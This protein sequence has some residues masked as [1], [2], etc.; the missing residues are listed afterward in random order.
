MQ[1]RAEATTYR[2]M[3]SF[4]RKCASAIST[5]LCRAAPAASLRDLEDRAKHGPMWTIVVESMVVSD[6]ISPE[7]T[8][9]TA[10][11]RDRLPRSPVA[12]HGRSGRDPFEVDTTCGAASAP[13]A[14]GAPGAPSAPSAPGA[15]RKVWLG[16]FAVGDGW[17]A[18]SRTVTS[19]P[20]S[21]RGVAVT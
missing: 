5:T 14:S 12:C 2:S 21:A 9:M 1:T 17:F 18:G 11:G 19:R 13:G 10:P 6:G 20:P 15:P 3:D 16:F 8:T 4:G 7:T